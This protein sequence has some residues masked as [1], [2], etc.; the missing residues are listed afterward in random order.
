[1]SRI[2][3]QVDDAITIE[4]GTDVRQAKQVLRNPRFLALFGS[5]I[6]TQVGGNMV[7]FGLTVTVFGLTGSNT[8]VSLL[9]L[10]FLVPAVVFGA[11][12][13]VFVDM[14]DRRQILIWSNFLRAGLYLLLLLFPDQL[15]VIY[16]VT[17]L[18]AT[19]TSFFGP[20]EAAMI[21]F[22]VKREQLLTANSF[23]ILMLQASFVL[24]FALLGPAAHRFLGMELLLTI[25]VAAYAVAGLLCWV[26][27]SA[28]PGQV[29]QASLA[30]ARRAVE[31]TFSQLREGLQYI[32]DHHNIFWSLTYLAITA[33][34]I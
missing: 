28:P 21:P 23:F 24:G 10:T 31:A 32:R 19:L 2:R 20:A 34:L 27:P 25:V 30:S 15:L 17:A 6:L 22:V 11:I 5:Q 29:G 1:M 16:L 3:E 7:L 33:S 13:G 18:V 8:S 9:L 26:L 4:G 12:A 14:F